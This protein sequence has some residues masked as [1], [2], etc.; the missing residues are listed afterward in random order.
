MIELALGRHAEVYWEAGCY[1]MRSGLSGVLLDASHFLVAVVVLGSGLLAYECAGATGDGRGDDPGDSRARGVRSWL[2]ATVLLGSVAFSKV[3]SPQYLLFLLPLLVVGASYPNCPG[4]PLR[5]SFEHL[6]RR[7]FL[8][9]LAVVLAISVLT[10]WVYPYHE[11]ALLALAPIAVLPL[12]L[13]N[14]LLVALFVAAGVALWSLVR[15]RE[16]KGDTV[17][18]EVA[19]CEN[20]A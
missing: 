3:L 14:A 11:E 2:L 15:V 6:K 10:V 5:Q 12:V 4:S 16:T 17:T 1:N 9:A 20:A 19:T 8:V 7:P 18:K 13:R